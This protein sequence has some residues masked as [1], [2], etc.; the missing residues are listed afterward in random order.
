MWLLGIKKCHVERE[1][2]FKADSEIN[3]PFLR[4]FLLQVLPKKAI[5]YQQ[6]MFKE[7]DVQT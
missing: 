2:H 3:V 1:A 5:K 7:H 6:N 4:W